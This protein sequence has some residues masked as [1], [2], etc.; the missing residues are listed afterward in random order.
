MHTYIHTYK[1]AYARICVPNSYRLTYPPFS[2]PTYLPTYIRI[3]MPAYKQASEQADRQAA[4]KQASKQ[5]SKNRYTHTCQE[6]TR[7]SGA[8]GLHY[9]QFMFNA[10]QLTLN[11][12]SP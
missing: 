2:L 3:C 4:S 7:I 5:A 10:S 1:P 9:V 11:P 12:K 8:V 6:G